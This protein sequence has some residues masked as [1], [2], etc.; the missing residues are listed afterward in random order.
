MKFPRAEMSRSRG[1]TLIELSV[2]LCVV[3]AL[4]GT[5]LYFS[6]K[7]GEWRSGRAA[8]EVLRG[9]YAAQRTYLSDH[10]TATVD[11]L[12]PDGLLPY[13]PGRPAEMPTVKS[14]DGDQ[15]SIKVTEMPPVVEGAGGD[16]YDPSGNPHDMLW[17]V[18]E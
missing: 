1:M 15:L 7:I 10:P 18:G 11:S 9:V 12:T 3:I 16:A 2:V 17:D 13:M 6:G 4:L 14:L 5:G 8:S